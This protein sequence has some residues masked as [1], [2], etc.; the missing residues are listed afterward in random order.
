MCRAC[1]GGQLPPAVS[2]AP[3]LPRTCRGSD[4]LALQTLPACCR[5]PCQV[6]VPQPLSCSLLPFPASPWQLPDCHQ[7]EAERTWSL[8][9]RS[10]CLELFAGTE[11]MAFGEMGPGRLLIIQNKPER[12]RVLLPHKETSMGSS[13]G[14]SVE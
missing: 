4:P 12:A 3:A 6:P 1:R 7:L 9:F 10:A 2:L 11:V 13:W 8:G 5:A 14:S